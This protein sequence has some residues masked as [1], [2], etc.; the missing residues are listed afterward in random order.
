[1]AEPKDG[2]TEAEEPKVEAEIENPVEAA[3]EEPVAD[4]VTSEPLGRDADD[5]VLDR[6]FGQSEQ[7]EEPAPVKP[8]ADLD[9]AYQILKRDGVPDDILKSVSKD[10]LMAWAGKA[11]KRQTDVDGYGK[12]M[13]ALEAE[14]AQLKSG[15]KAGDEELESFDEESDNPRGK[16]DTDDD[17]AGSD[18]DSKDPRYTAL[19]EEVSKLRLQQQEQ[20]L[21]GLQTQVEQ[22]ITFVQG[23]YGNPVDANAVLAE[24]DRLGRS[25]PGTYP[26]MIHL[27]QEAFANI[28]GPA[29]D[30]RRV[31]QPTARPTVGR[32]ERPTTPADAEDAVLEAL[33]EGR[34]L[35]EAKRLTRK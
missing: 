18:E 11:G 1:V 17:D 3:A 20:Q 14:N 35:S 32:N 22:A 23:Q 13:K 16:P 4:P 8:D 5:E 30:P 10:T 9:R 6:L 15:R 25:K 34:S 2:V 21:R 7:K 31:G 28:A 27:A 24:M 33:L 12:R 26:T 19:S 29:R